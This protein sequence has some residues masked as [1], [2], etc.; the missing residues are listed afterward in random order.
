MTGYIKFIKCD[1]VKVI[2]NLVSIQ[3][4]KVILF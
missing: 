4:F 2:K 1:I 3:I